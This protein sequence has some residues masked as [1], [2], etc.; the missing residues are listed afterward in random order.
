M[1][2]KVAIQGERGSYSHQAASLYFENYEP[3]FL[4]SFKEVFDSVGSGTADRGVVPIE[5]TTTG[6]I[7]KVVNLL[8]ERDV[9]AIGE[10]KVTVNHALL[11]PDGASIQTIKYVYSHPEAISQ[12]EDFLSSKGWQVIPRFDT[13]GSAREVAERGDPTFAAI[14]P[15]QAASLYGLKVLMRGI[16]D[17]KPNITRFYVVSK[18]PNWSKDADTTSA[19]FATR[20]VPGALWRALG[21]FARRNINLLWLESRPIRGEPWNYSFFV[22]FEGS[23][24][25]D[26]VV[27][28][29]DEL[30]ELSIW[31]KLVG[32]YKRWRKIS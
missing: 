21:A 2:L 26:Y 28:A 13:A 12:C 32:S 1:R 16:Q 30:K 20:H 29:L 18:N 31:V 11:A 14:A 23:L 7:R 27:E 24:Y 15:E 19:F 25:E 3:I 10:V 6:S 5:N 8:L 4:K 17:V 22:E 9:Y